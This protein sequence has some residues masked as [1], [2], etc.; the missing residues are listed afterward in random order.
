MFILSASRLQKV[1]PMIKICDRPSG[2]QLCVS[3]DILAVMYIT[4]L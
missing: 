3:T 2:S 1:N 4:L